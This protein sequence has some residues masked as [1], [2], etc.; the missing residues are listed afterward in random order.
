MGKLVKDESFSQ[1]IWFI[2][3]SLDK[4]L[5]DRNDKDLL[6]CSNGSEYANAELV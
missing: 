2:Y 4:D 1:L 6:D 3:L 5:I